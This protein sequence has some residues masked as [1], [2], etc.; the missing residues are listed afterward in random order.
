MWHETVRIS[1]T[2][3]VATPDPVYSGKGLED[4]QEQESATVQPAAKTERKK[5]RQ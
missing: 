5:E 4:W 1:P 3:S 2:K